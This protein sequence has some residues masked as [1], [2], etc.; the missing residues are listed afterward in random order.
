MVGLTYY[1]CHVTFLAHGHNYNSGLPFPLPLLLRFFA[2]TDSSY[3]TI[4]ISSSSQA[5]RAG[6]IRHIITR[7]S[8]PILQTAPRHANELAPI[9]EREGLIQEVKTI[10]K[11][12]AHRRRASG[13]ER[14]RECLGGRRLFE[15]T[16][17]GV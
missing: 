11:D 16:W 6:I 9:R 2:F 3:R 14:N 15:R 12:A 8:C 13:H 1:F 5:C 17:T 7:R 4:H 10:K